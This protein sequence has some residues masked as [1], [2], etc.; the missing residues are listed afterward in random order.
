MKRRDSQTDIHYHWLRFESV[1]DTSNSALPAN[2]CLR[3][4]KRYFEGVRI[5]KTYRPACALK[6]KMG[7]KRGAY[8][9]E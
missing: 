6:H 3:P 9:T 8:R 5:Y 1:R 2:R 4:P 7:Q